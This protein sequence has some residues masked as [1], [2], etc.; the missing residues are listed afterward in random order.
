MATGSSSFEAVSLE[1]VRQFRF[2]PPIVDGKPSSM[3]IR[4]QIR[5]RIMN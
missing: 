5:F 1:A 3:W 4:F 2:K